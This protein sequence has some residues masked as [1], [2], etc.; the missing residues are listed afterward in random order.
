MVPGEFGQVVSVNV[1]SMKNGEQFVSIFS[2]CMEHGTW[3]GEYSTHNQ[4][5]KTAVTANK[6]TVSA[7]PKYNIQLGERVAYKDTFDFSTGGDFAANKDKG[8][9][10][11]QLLSLGLTI[12]LYNDNASKG[13]KGIGLPDGSPITFDIS[14]PSQYHI[15]APNPPSGYTQGQTADITNDYMPLL[16]SYDGKQ[17]P[18][19]EQPTGIDVSQ[20]ILYSMWSINT[21]QVLLQPRLRT[22]I[23]LPKALADRA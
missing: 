13:M 12:Q 16:W 15:D 14:V 8:Q 18:H 19:P 1:K 17:A 6:V 5:E 23:C 4:T 2:A 10:I 7:A 20:V 11:G 3:N 9:V 22:S 21:V